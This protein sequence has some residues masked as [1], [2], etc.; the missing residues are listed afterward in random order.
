M[1]VYVRSLGIRGFKG[2]D[3]VWEKEAEGAGRLNL[4]EM[5][6]FKA[7]LL[8][9]LKIW[10]EKAEGRDKTVGE[11]TEALIEL[12]QALSVERK[13]E[14][15][16]EEFSA[17]GLMKEAREYEEL[18]GLVMELLERFYELLGT[19]TISKREYLDILSAG[20][21]ELKVG[22]IP[23]GADRVVAGD[24]KRTRLSEIK[25]LFFVG[26]NEGIVPENAEKGGLLTDREREVLKKSSLELAPTAREEGFMQRFYLYLMLTKPERLLFVSWSLL[27]AEGNM[28][29]LSAIILAISAYLR[30]S[31]EKGGDRMASESG[32]DRSGSGSKG[33]VRLAFASGGGKKEYGG[34]GKSL[35]LLL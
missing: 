35:L 4:E 23:A 1:E 8:A 31:S 28:S 26:V 27:S 2:W 7:E 24:L 18:Y 33:A 9:P 5:N 22:M 32:E 6:E 12:L 16:A 3:S 25:A 30:S 20:L 11:I 34:A 13:L 19:E 15:R 21:S 10:K 17:R 29:M 14:Q